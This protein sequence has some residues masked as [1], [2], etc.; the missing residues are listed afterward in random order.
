M[1]LASE[2]FKLTNVHSG[3]TVA[4]QDLKISNV[5]S[6]SAI[7]SWYPSNSNLEHMVLLNGLKIST[8]PPGVYQLELKGLLPS[9]MYRCTIRMKDPIAV[10]EEKPLETQID[11]RTLPRGTV[12]LLHTPSVANKF[13]KIFYFLSWA[14]RSTAKCTVR[15]W[16]ARWD[17]ISNMDTG[18]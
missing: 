17:I 3:A 4:A 11:F 5:T 8:C 9:K 6:N 15:T 10:L 12:H 2:K 18:H 14:S 13:S 7:I 1:A 16:T